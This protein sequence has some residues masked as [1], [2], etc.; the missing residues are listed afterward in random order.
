MKKRPFLSGAGRSMKGKKILHDDASIHQ[1]LQR[2]V[3]ML[4]YLVK[5]VVR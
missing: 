3:P 4:V 2:T 5:N 1:K